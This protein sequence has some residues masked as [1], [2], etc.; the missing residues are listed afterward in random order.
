M[1]TLR[2]R[3]ELNT[4]VSRLNSSGKILIA[5]FMSKGMIKLRVKTIRGKA[6]GQTL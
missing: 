2:H 1:G 5:Q 4:R 6:I 3:A